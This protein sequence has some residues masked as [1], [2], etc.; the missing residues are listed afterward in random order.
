MPL[1]Y[2]RSQS[3]APDWYADLSFLLARLALMMRIASPS[4]DL[5]NV[6]ATIRTRPLTERPQAEEPSFPRRVR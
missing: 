1:E 2:P 5:L 3:V 6:Y 4:P